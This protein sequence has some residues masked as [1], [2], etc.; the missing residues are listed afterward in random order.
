MSGTLRYTAKR[1]LEEPKGTALTVARTLWYMATGLRGA[2][3][4]GDREELFAHSLQSARAGGLI[5][6]FGVADGASINRIAA[7]VPGEAVYGFDSFA[8]LPEGWGTLGKGHFKAEAL[9]MV[10]ENVGLVV[11]LFQ[12][13]LGAF[14]AE[15]RGKVRFLH[16]DADLYSSTTYVLKALLEEGRIQEGTVVQFDELFGYLYWWR[17]GE[18][19]ALKELEEAGKIEY[20]FIGYSL[21][22]QGPGQ[23]AI[24][25]K[26]VR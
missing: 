6:E 14:L 1:L 23:A 25:I 4:F 18:Y 5:L 21:K 2:R 20:G 22:G 8:G 11:G 26:R 10:R 12:E 9:P 16:L 15:H 7:L 3:R 17:D 24:V 13:T 19:R